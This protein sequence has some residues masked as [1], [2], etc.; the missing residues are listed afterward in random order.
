MIERDTH[1][2]THIMVF[3][4]NYGSY[5]S[6]RT[7]MTSVDEAARVAEGKC[8]VTL[9]VGDNTAKDWEGIPEDITPHC[10]VRSFPYHLNHGYLGCAFRMMSEVGWEEVSKASFCIISNVDLTIAPDFFLT[11]ANTDWPTDAAWLAPDIYTE[12]LQRHDNPFMTHRPRKRD[13]L[14]W[15]LL[16]RW[17]ALYG[18]L[19]KV[20][21]LKRA[22]HSVSD[23]QT[24]IYAGHGSLMVFTGRFMAK[25][26]FL[27]FPAFMY[28][29]EIFFAELARRDKLRTYYAPS[30]HV[31]NTGRVSTGKNDFRWLCRQNRQSLDTLKRTYFR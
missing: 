29:E 2:S 30:L 4:V 28:G 6:L 7:F 3:C 25:H 5:E 14:R 23:K 19:E 1:T 26:A 20:Y 31:S 17:P 15:Q 27:Q 21:N 13:F 12:R 8:H 9:C 16:Y 22:H 10:T 24:V 11:L 18:L